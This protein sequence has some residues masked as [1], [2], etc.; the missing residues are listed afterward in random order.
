MTNA[1]IGVCSSWEITQCTTSQAN[2]TSVSNVGRRLVIQMIRWQRRHVWVMSMWSTLST[3]LSLSWA[4]SVQ[5]LLYIEGIG[6]YPRAPVCSDLRCEFKRGQ[7][8]TCKSTRHACCLS[9]A[10]QLRAGPGR[11][12]RGVAMTKNK[13]WPSSSRVAITRLLR[14]VADCCWWCCC[15]RSWRV[16]EQR[17]TLVSPGKLGLRRDQVSVLRPPRILVVKLDRCADRITRGQI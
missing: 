9:Q 17:S 14:S 3:C 5:C 8:S 16:G 4:V 6:R 12:A 13:P 11:A 10:R 15:L 2:G 7:P 1:V